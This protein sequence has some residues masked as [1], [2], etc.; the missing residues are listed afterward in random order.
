ME[1]NEVSVMSF[2]LR[3]L[4]LYAAFL[5]FGLSVVAYGQEHG[6]KLSIELSKNRFL[7]SEPIWLDVTL[8]NIGDDTIKILPLDPPCQGGGLVILLYDSLGQAVPYSG[9]RYSFGARSGFVLK[10]NQYFYDCFDVLDYYHTTSK[11]L[12][13]AMLPELPTGRYEVQVRYWNVQ[14]QRLTFHVSNP[15]EGEKE[16]LDLIIKGFESVVNEQ[17]DSAEAIFRF[18]A[19]RFPA[20][21][22]AEKAG[23]QFL[24]YEELLYKF[25]NSGKSGQYLRGLTWDQ[26]EGERRPKLHKLISEL[27]PSR[28]RRF[29]EQMIMYIDQ[30]PR[31]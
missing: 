4:R 15:S 17:S 29:V 19:E 13:K 2:S 22:Y 18:V 6:L 27:P 5:F 8:T 31:K 21:V 10:P 3:I 28:A 20:S 23:Q 9:P 12:S 7:L 1:R 11:D 14:S 30:W 16:V 25:P 26:T 24:R